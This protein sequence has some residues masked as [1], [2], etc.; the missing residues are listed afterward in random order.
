MKIK[1]KR[2]ADFNLPA[3]KNEQINICYHL[4]KLAII[5]VVN[6]YKHEENNINLQHFE[7]ESENEKLESRECN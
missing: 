3:R 7:G 6:I 1:C 4:S 2:I 5:D